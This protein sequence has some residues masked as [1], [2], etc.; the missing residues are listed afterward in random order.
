MYPV[1]GSGAKHLGKILPELNI[2]CRIT[3]RITQEGLF[4]LQFEGQSK[5]YLIVLTGKEGAYTFNIGRISLG[6]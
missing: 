4:A 3:T 1:S 2:L 6:K 5:Q